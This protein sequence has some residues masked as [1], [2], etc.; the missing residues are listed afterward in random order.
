MIGVF[1]KNTLITFV[2]RVLTAVFGIIITIIIARALGAEGQGIYSLAVLLPNTL[3]TFALFGI[4]T[5]TIFYIGKKKYSPPEIFGNNI[6]FT[7]FFSL[8]SVLVGL[9]IIYFFGGKIFPGVE[10]SY[11]FL[12]LSVLPFNIFFI[13]I[14]SVLLGLQKIKK[15]NFIAFFQS[16]LYLSLIAALVL[17]LRLGIGAAILVQT[18][19][20]LLASLVL[21]FVAKKESGGMVLKLNKEYVKDATGYGLKNYLSWVLYFL[22]YRINMF[23]INIFLNPIAVGVYFIAVRL[24]ESIWLIS[25]SVTTVLFPKV[26]SENNE[27]NLKEFTPLVFRNVLFVTFFVA[28]LLFVLSHWLI[29]FFYSNE[30]LGSV[31]P[32]QILLFGTPLIA[33]WQVLA[34]DIGGRGKPMINTYISGFSVILNITANIFLIPKLGITGAALATDI[35]YSALFLITIFVYAKISQN[36]IKEIILPRQ[37]DYRF[38]KSFLLSFKNFKKIRVNEK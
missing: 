27:K 28:F 10:K 34:N 9:V 18:I 26:S 11:L 20:Y 8:L 15:Y 36:K 14:S 6:F 37:I 12:A 19:S 17:A 13:L 23:L 35:S 7:L 38:Y 29:V 33:G 24:A 1:T 2:T 22:H 4:N 31:L 16:F 30:F 25:Q 32:L 21:F 3:F 5:S